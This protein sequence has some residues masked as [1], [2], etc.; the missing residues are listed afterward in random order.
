MSIVNKAS[1]VVF[2]KNLCL[3]FAMFEV[4]TK[5]RNIPYA[6]FSLYKNVYGNVLQKR[7]KC[8][9]WTQ[10]SFN[11]S[12]SG[13][14]RKQNLMRK[15]PNI[16]YILLNILRMII[17]IYHIFRKNNRKIVPCDNI[18]ILRIFLYNLEMSCQGCDMTF[19]INCFRFEACDMTFVINCFRFISNF[20]MTS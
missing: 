19:H 15:K 14:K 17:L 2:F 1:L 20:S 4:G 11:L 9:N 10:Q 8:E 6:K 7:T 13:K 5:L 18:N 16:R 3:I 12:F